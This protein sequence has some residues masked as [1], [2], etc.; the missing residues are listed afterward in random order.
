MK[1]DEKIWVME[2]NGSGYRMRQTTRKNEAIKD[3]A[4][5][6]VVIIGLIAVFL[7]I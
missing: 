7:L 5:I 3:W 4:A 6:A 2:R 1:D